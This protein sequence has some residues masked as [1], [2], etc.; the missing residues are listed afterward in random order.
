MSAEAGV[1]AAI[2]KWGGWLLGIVTS[3]LVGL[4]GY[5]LKE[6]NEV[7]KEN[8]K[9]IDNMAREAAETKV[10]L[11]KHSQIIEE[12]STQINSL[13]E[14]KDKVLVYEAHSQHLSEDMSDLKEGQKDLFREIRSLSNNTH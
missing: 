5:I 14:I 7:I 10:L 1:A 2:I 9:A 3:L 13:S 12:L 4:M 8:R 6:K 11:E